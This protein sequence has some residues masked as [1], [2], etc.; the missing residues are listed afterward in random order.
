[1]CDNCDK[2]VC[3]HSL[4]SQV[5]KLE[6][7]KI[8]S[9]LGKPKHG[10]GGGGGGYNIWSGSSINMMEDMEWI[11][12][13]QD[14]GKWQDPIH[15]V[16]NLT[17]PFNTENFLTTSATTVLAYHGR[18]WFM[19]LVTE[20]TG[21]PEHSGNKKYTAMGMKQL[22]VIPTRQWHIEAHVLY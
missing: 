14:K 3:I 8:K 20:M 17:V 15:M 16:T 1:M 9:Q 2:P 6:R 19:E 7:K 21:L 13:G 4:S 10:W 18:F 12:L 11:H 5:E 22:P